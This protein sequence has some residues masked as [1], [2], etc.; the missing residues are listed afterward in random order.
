MPPY[1]PFVGGYTLVYAS[2]TPV[3]ASVHP[4]Y[5][6][7]YTLG[8]RNSFFEGILLGRASQPGPIPRQKEH[9]PERSRPGH[10]ARREPPS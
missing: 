1:C 2:R 9:L 4:V 7:F 5:A 3:Y 10:L 8:I 6:S